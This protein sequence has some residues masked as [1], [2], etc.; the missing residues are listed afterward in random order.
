[1]KRW[2]RVL[3]VVAAF[4]VLVGAS[5]WNLI[6]MVFY[7]IVSPT[8][9]LDTSEDWDGGTSYVKLQYSD[10]SDED[11]LD[12]YV[13]DGEEKEPLFIMIH[14]GGF[15]L[16]DSQADQAQYIYRYFRDHG[17]ACASVNYRLAKDAP[18]PAAIEDC[19]AAVRFL[20]AN[21]D[22]YGY[23][24]DR[25]VV[26]GESAGG[27]LATMVAS[28]NDD[29]YSGVS[30]IGEEDLDEPVSASVDVLVDLYGCI[31][32][33]TMDE[34]FTEIGVPKFIRTISNAWLDEAIEGTGFDS[35]EEYWLGMNYDDMTDEFLHEEINPET[36]VKENLDPS[37]DLKV[38]IRH[39]DA[40]LT[41]PYLQSEHLAEVMSESMDTPV[42]VVESDKVPDSDAR[43]QIQMLPNQKHASDGF[44]SD[45][46]L[47]EIQAYLDGIFK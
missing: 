22:K 4:L 33:S 19:K 1:M 46:R 17:Y 16:N 3:I 18:Y 7:S 32:F 36:Y 13:P 47:A 44:Y 24:A 27:Y 25:V 35:C 30:F 31:D 6:R 26:A 14:G 43:L 45:D 42:V 5:Q 11:Y 20:K 15:V 28:T 2:Q 34:Q 40:D 39:G 21:A 29:E 8:V 41:V 23:D 12:L 9:E 38:L 10:V 37:S